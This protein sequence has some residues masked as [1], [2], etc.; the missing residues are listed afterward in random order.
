VAFLGLVRRNIGL[1]SRSASP[2]L[3]LVALRW[4]VGAHVLVRLWPPPS[5]S[6]ACP[7]AVTHFSDT[8]FPRVPPSRMCPS[9]LEAYAAHSQGPH[10]RR[11]APSRAPRSTR[12]SGPAEHE[13]RRHGDGLRSGPMVR[14]LAPAG[15]SP[16]R[17][18]AR[19]FQRRLA[20]PRAFRRT[21][22]AAT[23]IRHARCGALKRSH[24][25]RGTESELPKRIH[26][27]LRVPGPAWLPESDSPVGASG[28]FFVPRVREPGTAEGES[29]GLGP[30][31]GRRV[32]GTRRSWPRRQ[33]SPWR[34]FSCPLGP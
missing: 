3:Q 8:R 18:V 6:T 31:S 4:R 5:V 20:P 1:L 30:E 19:P 23:G 25:G 12:F 33:A 28:W 15:R 11:C 32:S 24:R 17:R 14:C 34:G 29:T 27:P 7:V 2:P 10:A 22:S 21:S 26:D 16:A 13:K 9:S